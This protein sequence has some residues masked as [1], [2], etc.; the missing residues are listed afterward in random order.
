[1]GK[2]SFYAFVAIINLLVNLYLIITD[3]FSVN[4]C[5]YY[6]LVSVVLVAWSIIR[7]DEYRLTFS[8]ALLCYLITTQLGLIIPYVL[9]NGEALSRFAKHILTFLGSD[10]LPMA[11]LLGALSVNASALGIMLSRQRRAIRLRMQESLSFQGED[12]RRFLYA[13]TILL[14]IVFLF[15]AYHVATGGMRLFGSYGD[16]MH[17]SAYKA[18]R[19]GLILVLFAVGTLY[20][21][22]AGHVKKHWKSW[23]LW[24]LI[25]AIFALNG[26]KG[27]FL[28]ALLAVFGM[29]GTMGKRISKGTVLLIFFL[30]FIVI[31]TVTALRGMGV[32][33]NLSEMKF[34]A[35]SAF[36]EMGMQIRTTV[37]TLEGLADGTF[38]YLNGMSYIQPLI[39]IMTPF[40]E[41]H[42]ATQHITRMYDGWGYNQAA[43]S[44]L[45][46]GVWGV[47]LYFFIVSYLIGRSETH[48]R[49]ARTLAYWGTVVCI[50][51]NATR[52]YF[53]FVPGQI[54]IVTMIY[55]IALHVKLP[56]L[57]SGAK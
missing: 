21:A 9:T 52:N 42:I 55:F 49:S 57:T 11:V 38:D 37:V 32:A 12:A 3:N 5:V 51:V 33:G 31:P 1:M 45:N 53:A 6:A 4:E 30:L 26:N 16:Y 28:Y 29:Q 20:I 18:S 19:Y 47:V 8:A 41:H 40:S 34:T 48:I 39:N 22:S 36:T 15:F 7:V 50:L 14:T 17:S 23:F 27:E 24:S 35:F 25:A 43:E 56:G 2:Q 13:G 44:Y 10:N 54:V 46:F